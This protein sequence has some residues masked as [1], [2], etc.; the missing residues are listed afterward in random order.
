[1]TDF[2]SHLPWEMPGN[3]LYLGSFPG[4]YIPKGIYTPRGKCPP[5]WEAVGNEAEVLS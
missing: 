2:V 5:C 3:G 4:G 1:M